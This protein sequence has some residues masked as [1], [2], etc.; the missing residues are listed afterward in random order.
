MT[1]GLVEP[2]FRACRQKRAGVE[3]RR[4]ALGAGGKEPGAAPAADGSRRPATAPRG[5]WGIV[6]PAEGAE[7]LKDRR[8]HRLRRRAAMPPGRLT[9]E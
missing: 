4:A 9:K 5:R 7:Q 3:E 8:E 2:R 1:A 6:G